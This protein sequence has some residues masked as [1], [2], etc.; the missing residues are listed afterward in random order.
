MKLPALLAVLLLAP[1]AGCEDKP[2]P[3]APPKPGK[4][5]AT[6]EFQLAVR[7]A[8]TIIGEDH[9]SVGQFATVLSSLDNKYPEDRQK[10][11]DLS[12]EAGSE[13]EA[14]GV[15]E[16]LLGLMQNVDK[17]GGPHKDYATALKAY[18]T[19]RKPAPRR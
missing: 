12:L 3:G 5:A 14:A 7:N 17:A 8:R 18:V 9:P 16:P 13:L 2:E 4:I 10:I 6:P 15:T 11:A 1:M 19:T